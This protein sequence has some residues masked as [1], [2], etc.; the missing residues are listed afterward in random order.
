VR[1]RTGLSIM[2]ETCCLVVFVAAMDFL[3][4]PTCGIAPPWTAPTPT[5][6]ALL[7]A[8]TEIGP[9]ADAGLLRANRIPDLARVAAVGAADQAIVG[10]TAPESA[11]T[12]LRSTWAWDWQRSS[13]CW[14]WFC[15]GR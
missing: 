4:K 5:P 10:R 7:M 3:A 14:Q 6:L 12:H 13:L 1:E 11:S 15:S 8:Q 2:T 9:V